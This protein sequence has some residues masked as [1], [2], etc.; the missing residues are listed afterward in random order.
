MTQP[1]D[2]DL[3][4]Q[5]RAIVDAA[6]ERMAL[7]LFKDWSGEDFDSLVRLMRKLADGINGVETPPLP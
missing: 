6:R 5:L 1:N 7:V 3:R 4:R 2:T